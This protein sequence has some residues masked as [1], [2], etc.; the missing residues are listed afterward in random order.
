M[1]ARSVNT[2]RTSSAGRLFDAV[3]AL[4]GLRLINTFEGQAAMELEWQANG[5]QAPPLPFICHPPAVNS[6]PMV[7]DWEPMIIELLRDVRRGSPVPLMAARF[8]STLTAI[9][10][11]VAERCG[12]E[13]VVLSGGC[14]QN[15]I[16]TEAAIAELRAR[17][18]QPYWHQ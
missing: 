8:H 18:F 14:F 9:I 15:R 11:T 4:I 1:L 13:R 3:S 6:S 16:L 2:P 10:G 7:V 5:V 12:N 17:G